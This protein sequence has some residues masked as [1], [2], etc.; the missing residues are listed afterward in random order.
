M[1]EVVSPVATSVDPRAMNNGGYRGTSGIDKIIMHHNAT[2]NP[3]VA[4][5]TWLAGS[6]AGTSAHYE[7]TDNAII[8]TLGEDYIAYHA[9]GTGG[10]DV[11]KIAN[12][13]GRSIGLEH[14]NSTGEA[15]GWQVS[16]ATIRNSAKLVADICARYGLPLNR[17]TVMLHR[18]V[19]STACPGGLDID[20]LMSYANGNS[21][22]PVP[23]TKPAPTPTAPDQI[24]NVG[25][26]VRIDGTFSLDDLVPWN[27]GW[28]TVSTPLLIPKVDYHNYI[29][30][31]PLTETDANGNP[32]ADNDFSNAG[33][34]YFTFGNQLFRVTAVDAASDSVEVQIGGEPVWMPAGPVTEVSN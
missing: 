2:T 31:G 25:S 29:P 33:H 19:T 1:A 8:N 15:G 12:P 23:D 4:I 6:P 7:I 10:A 24:L 9:G 20:R 32:T 18:E 34:S 27:G 11:P 3:D 21:P 26:T 17:D 16:D 30:V 5:N 22:L 13:N 28:Y 14:V